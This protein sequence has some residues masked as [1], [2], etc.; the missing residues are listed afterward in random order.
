MIAHSTQAQVSLDFVSTHVY[1]N[2]LSKDVLGTDEQ[3]DRAEMV[4]RAVQKV[5]TQVKSSARPDLPILWTEYNASYKNEIDVTDAA[6]MGP[7]LANNIRLC[8]GLTTV[9]S[10]WTFSDVFEE[11]GVIKT[12][13]YG[14]YGLIAEGGV[15]KPA[16]NAFA[17]LHRLGEQRSQP[18]LANALV[19]KRSDGTLAIAVWNYAAA[20][21]TGRARNVHLTV[22]RMDGHA[23]LPCRNPGSRSRVGAPSVAGD[24]E[25]RRSYA[26]TVRGAP[27]CGGRNPEAGWHVQFYA[28]GIWTGVG[29]SAASLIVMISRATAILLSVLLAVSGATADHEAPAVNTDQV[30][31]VSPADR[32]FLEDLEHRSFNYF[33][34]QGGPWHRAGAGSRASQRRPRQGPQ[35]RY[36]QPRRHRFRPHRHLHWRGAWLDHEERGGRSHPGDFGVLCQ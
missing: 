6:F 27:A 4:S 21:V 14:G 8:D 2:D 24:G 9:M 18:G 22:R 34:E 28:P 13:F 33:W 32:T 10:Y 3:V 26:R 5:K 36:R 30:A 31:P 29:R 25:P 15:P 35:P 7:W 11:Q 12:P 16:F 23:A 20:E 19:T 17:M 1:G